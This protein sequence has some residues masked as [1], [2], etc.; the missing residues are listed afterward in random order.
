MLCLR[1]GKPRGTSLQLQKSKSKWGGSSL[2]SW[3]WFKY[4]CRKNPDLFLSFFSNRWLCCVVARTVN[5]KH[6]RVNDRNVTEEKIERACISDSTLKSFDHLVS[7]SDCGALKKQK[8]KREKTKRFGP[9]LILF[10]FFFL[11]HS[12]LYRQTPPCCPLLVQEKERRPSSEDRNRCNT[13]L[14]PNQRQRTGWRVSHFEIK[15]MKSKKYVW[16]YKRSQRT[17]RFSAKVIWN[18]TQ[19]R[20]TASCFSADSVFSS[21]FS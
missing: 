6:L 9:G 18:R 8:K 4:R 5:L 10:F 7:V 17:S 19:Q 12:R 15:S 1:Y 13:R 16:L 3:E 11:V 21:G 20:L 2:I 14:C